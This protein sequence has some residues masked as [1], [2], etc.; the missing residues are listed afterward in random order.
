MT[1]STKKTRKEG[2]REHRLLV[3]LKTLS[4]AKASRMEKML[5]QW[6]LTLQWCYINKYMSPYNSKY[7]TTIWYISS[8]WGFAFNKTK[9]LGRPRIDAAEEAISDLHEQRVPTTNYGKERLWA[10]CFWISFS[11]RILRFEHVFSNVSMT[12]AFLRSFLLVVGLVIFFSR[13]WFLP[14]LF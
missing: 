5:L 3:I 2:H 9:T 10:M 14:V 1:G 8:F 12:K 7:Y 11:F 13:V 4:I 6:H